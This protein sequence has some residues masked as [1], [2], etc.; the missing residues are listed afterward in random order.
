MADETDQERQRD[1]HRVCQGKADGET[2]SPALG[3]RDALGEPA[4]SFDRS[5]NG[6][7]AVLEL[8]ACGLLLG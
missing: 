7:G 3:M 8:P 1:A 5:L 6:V 2:A 4:D